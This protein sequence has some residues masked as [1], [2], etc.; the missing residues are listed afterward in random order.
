MSMLVDGQPGTR[1]SARD[2]GLAYGD[3][4]F[5]TTRCEGGRLLSWGRHYAKLQA[6]CAAL[7]IACPDEATLLHD[8]VILAPRDHAVKITVTRG[9]SA[10]GY[11]TDPSLAAT[12]IVQLAPLPQYDESLF[13]RGASVHVCDWPLG[14]QP[15]LAGVKHLNRLDQVMARREWDDASIFDGLM[16]NLRGEVVEGVISN[17]FM[18]NGTALTTHPLHDCGVAGVTRA[19][20]LDL[21]AQL[22]WRVELRPFTMH[23]LLC[24][25]AVCLTNSL[26]G[27][28]PVG[29][30]GP[31]IW[32]DMQA[33]KRLRAE[34]KILAESESAAC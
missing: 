21:A 29:C 6:D 27:V 1:I 18:L 22:G 26:A 13:E 23:E 31:A 17:L 8:V 15:R 16:L 33:I 11:A 4:V 19:A 9:E 2:R 12:R 25:D 32:Y 34:W 28:V 7:G 5:R 30:I 24:A 3:G 20:V 14:L 10:R